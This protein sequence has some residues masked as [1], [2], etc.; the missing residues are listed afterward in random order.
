MAST[1]LICLQSFIFYLNSFLFTFFDIFVMFDICIYTKEQLT[2]TVGIR[3]PETSSQQI[4]T[5]P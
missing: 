5:S 1:T 2:G 4:F 3:L